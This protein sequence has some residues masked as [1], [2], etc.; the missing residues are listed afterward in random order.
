LR[1]FWKLKIAG[2]DLEKI[3][4]TIKNTSKL[5]VCAWILQDHMKS[6]IHKKKKSRKDF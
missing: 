1:N 2:I 5:L 3:E 4:T 6:D